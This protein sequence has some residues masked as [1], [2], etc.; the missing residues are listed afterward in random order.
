MDKLTLNDLF[1]AGELPK[2][3]PVPEDV[4]LGLSRERDSVIM[5]DGYF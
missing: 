2:R 5:E 4:G 3:E 1:K